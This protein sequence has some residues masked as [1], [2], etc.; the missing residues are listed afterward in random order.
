MATGTPRSI[1]F[2]LSGQDQAIGRGGEAQAPG[3]LVPGLR[4]RVAASVRL[5]ARRGAGDTVRVD[6]Q[7]GRDVVVL[8]IANGPSLV[9]HPETARDLLQAQ[10]TADRGAAPGDDVSVT[11]QLHWEGLEQFGAATARGATR[12]L[13]GDVLVDAVQVI[14]GAV[15]DAVAD[16]AIDE[17]VRRVDAQVD[18]GVYALA[19]EVLP[20]LKGSASPLPAI[21]P[22]ADGGPLL[23]FVHGTF[24]NTQGTFA[25]LWSQHPQRVRG[26]F[27]SYGGRVYALDHPTLGASPIDN[28]LALAAA[29][30]A[31]ARLHLV[32]HSR[33][34]LVAEV[35]ARACGAR[36]L[37]EAA[38]TLFADDRFAAHRAAL[39]TLHD[40]VRQKNLRVERVVRVACPA[41]GTLLA[42]GRLDAF[43]SVF[44][45]TLELAGIP[46]LPELV[47]F[48]GAVA[49]GR[50]DPQKI[51]G[52]Q[53]QMPGSE[54]IQWLHAAE[55]PL[56]GQLRVVA[57]DMQGDSVASWIKTLL[58]DAFYWTDNDLV[59]QTRSMYGGAPR[60]GGASFLLD[61]G[62]VVS[63]F[64]YFDNERT[65]DAIVG[66]L[67][68]D[69]P[70]G[71]Q[72]IGPM[73]WSGD[74]ATGARGAPV[75]PA[76]AAAP[77]SS[78]PAVFVLP[79][80]LGSNL[81]VDG[82]RIWL[83]WRLVNGLQRLRYVAGQPDDVMPDGLI[84][85]VYDDLVAFLADSHEVI[86]FAFDWRRPLE[87][88]ARRLGA[89][90][91][92]ALAARAQSGKP[93]RLLAHSMGGLL[94]RTLQLECPP[95]WQRM[96]ATAG[97]RV[98]LLGVPNAGTWTPMQMLT[99]DETFGGTLTAFG[100]PFRDAEARQLLAQCPGL[101]QLQAG[102]LDEHM[103]LGQAAT[104]QQLAAADLERVRRV[105]GWHNLPSQV[106]AYAWGVP[107]QPVLDAAVALRRRLDAQRDRDLAPFADRVLHVVGHA[108]STPDGFEDGADG[109][110]YL[111]APDAGDGRV[112]LASALLPGVRTWFI[113]CDH[114]RMPSRREAFPAL[115]E[116]L[117]TG[118]TALL[119]PQPAPGALAAASV[120]T[121]RLR[122]SR[123]PLVARPPASPPDIQRLASDQKPVTAP[124]PG[125]ALRISV[126]H[127]DLKFVRQPLMIGHYRGMAIS[128]TEAVVNAL[129]G[130]TMKESLEIGRYPDA[131]GSQQVFANNGTNRDNP[132][133]LPR[134]PAVI[135]VG[136][137]S[138]GK[139]VASDL[140]Y[141]A[142]QGVIAWAQKIV[143]QSDGA[144]PLFE[145]AAALIGSGGSG[146][147]AGQ[148]AQLIVNGV[149]EA[150]E[151]LADPRL[152]DGAWPRVGHLH[153]VEV[154]LDR[155]TEA[156]RALQVQAAAAPGR[157]QVDDLV[158]PGVGGLPR[159][160]DSGYRGANYDLIS[161]VADDDGRGG[162]VIAYTLDTRRARAEVRAQA[163]QGPLL[164][165][166]VRQ[167]SNDRNQDVQIGR[168]LFKLL[169]PVDLEPYLGGTT[170]MLIE[171]NAG[172]AGIP[173][174]LLD[175]DNGTRGGADARPWAIRSKLLR[176]LRL[177]DFRPRVIDASTD[178]SVLVIGEPYV[179]DRAYPR[180]PGARREAN[181]V[182]ARLRAA[183]ALGE[184]RVR[185]LVSP[186]DESQ[187][188]PDA[189]AVINALME[190]EWRIVHIAGHGE[191]PQWDEP[192][193]GAAGEPIVR[194]DP[195]G[196]VLSDRIFLGPREI[197]N[198]RV[199]PE[200][201]F[202]NC[203]HLGA[204]SPEELLQ[205]ERAGRYN[206]AQ[207]AADVAESLIRI[208]VRCVVAA[209]WAVDD[210]A[211]MRFATT[212]YD[213][214]LRGQRF[215]DAVAIA[216]EA[217]WA[218]GDNN[219]WAAYQCY[220]DPDWY[221]R[222]AGAD[223]QR[224]QRSLADEFAG[225]ASPPALCLALDA[226]VVQ[227]RYEARD[228]LDQ[229]PKIR[230]LEARFAPQWG[231][232]G[233][234]A[235]AFG[236]AWDAAG[237]RTAAIGWF[238]RA[239][240]APD[241]GASLKAGE[242]LGN[243]QA[244]DAWAAVD[245]AHRAGD[246]QQLR[247]AAEAA[248][249]AIDEAMR[250][251]TKMVALHP[252]VE[253]LS[254][255]G[256][257]F[258]RRA[259]MAR[260][261]GQD[262]GEDLRGMQSSYARAEDIARA[263]GSPIFYPALNRVAAQLVLAGGAPLDVAGCD[264]IRREL[265]IRTRDDPDFWSVVGL[266]EL[267]LYEAVAKGTLV[268]EKDG[269]LGEYA[270]LQRRVAGTTYW[271]SVA[272]QL[273]FVLDAEPGAVD[274]AHLAAAAE[275]RRVVEGY[276]AAVA[277]TAA[278]SSSGR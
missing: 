16:V 159:P 14:T 63:H 192:A 81:A 218:L 68:Q 205:A 149:R 33:G 18:P 121:P 136:L 194:G 215:I 69:Q 203:C 51:P 111:E 273:R 182:A 181:A 112:T 104:W 95:T 209:G 198:M 275:L 32:T 128:G 237:D 2:V 24:S 48:L 255:L 244:R 140:V 72:V 200:L 180:L 278:R 77:A 224:P 41:R 6:A 36:Q 239:L 61:A 29:L 141:T 74:S 67:T 116:L 101:L 137:G 9:L 269:I 87:A 7:P 13:L 144:P 89:A 184:A 123:A 164:R 30:P 21:P 115:L 113:D 154:Y 106:G 23:V 148:S 176:K 249:G 172:T 124:Q 20:R 166:L 134:P 12:G 212:F 31:G 39:Q 125:G 234:V 100:A 131:P 261:T 230:H 5:G 35:L 228:G 46:V 227:S 64:N 208:G 90:V 70:Q 59:V 185:A 262:P 75:A 120:G 158:R 268:A 229:R 117:Q 52:L 11:S 201:V 22:P 92:A 135:V 220:G 207:F 178:A 118:A 271:S 187:P 60:A 242:Q 98:V 49:R 165:E 55:Q 188:G 175:T 161:A 276:A 73:S 99:A 156:L 1:T 179:N 226:L 162:S 25:K 263:Q 216:R 233:S 56:P 253:R 37:D 96:L 213:A 3:P 127:G 110:V 223:A 80:I 122:P 17:V 50:T 257:A 76:A 38:R 267:R 10:A 66:A 195:H 252:T 47:D 84:G 130:G 258:K 240:A 82:A 114:G 196:V 173:W 197:S 248:R 79:G 151:R 251:L 189:R 147:S 129:I 143:E 15:E 254:L 193:A 206:R 153:L 45:W 270:D 211:A 160:P 88:E 221:L 26:L 247:V 274:A 108:A 245:A 250:T 139:L 43:F 231:S 8:Q 214:L 177:D 243:L 19:P 241:A 132:L 204:R 105:S 202:V 238:R 217:A 107:E 85:P 183:G 103:G 78:K 171:L 71:F 260:A 94:A 168:T 169:V 93:V 4:G 174:E 62:G 186:D 259:M 190:S 210:A 167:G 28:A 40:T 277:P 42:S 54:L 83:G 163:T 146:I 57:G 97:A 34:G 126:T 266:T 53:A 225:V 102:L 58:A 222:R 256:S 150:N 133:Q 119:P 157:F 142:R 265:A 272:D 155:A 91:E 191:P 219:T 44:K 138:E 264:E 109:F 86:P 65:A 152:A 199:V 235:E 232:I 170:E 145:I 27:D 236:R 246:P